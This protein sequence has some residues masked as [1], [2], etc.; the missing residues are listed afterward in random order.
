MLPFISGVLHP[1]C[2]C[3]GGSLQAAEE[4]K[5]THTLPPTSPLLPP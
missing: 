3:V 4:V 5:S 2:V 1:V